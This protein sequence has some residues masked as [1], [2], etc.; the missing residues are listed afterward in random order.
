MSGT[1]SVAIGVGSARS[2]STSTSKPGYAGVITVWPFAS[3]CRT[4]LQLRGV[5]HSP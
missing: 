2:A 4:T 3:K 1:V 5:T